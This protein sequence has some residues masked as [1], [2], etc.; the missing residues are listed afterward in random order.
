MHRFKNIL[1][2]D[3]G[4]PGFVR[5]LRRATDLARRNG[6]R[7]TLL[8]VSENVPGPT[9]KIFELVGLPAVQD[10]GVEDARRR[11]EEIVARH[12]END[13]R[14]EVVAVAGTPFLEVI[15]QVLRGENDLVIVNAEGGARS[16]FGSTVT[17]LLR[18]C[19]CPV[20]VLRPE[21]LDRY[22]R[23]LAAVE[24]NPEDEAREGLNR[25]ILEVATSLARLQDADL[26]IASAWSVVGEAAIRSRIGIPP[27]KLE[28]IMQQAEHESRSR[29][30]RLLDEV[31]TSDLELET[32]IAHGSP[33]VLIPE[34]G[35]EI[36]TEL[37]VIGTVGRTGIAGLLIGNT[38]E[39]ILSD[40][41]CPVLAIKPDGFRT[42][43]SLTAA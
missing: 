4:K 40:V 28:E 21:P 31:D 27:E 39:S 16:W 2:Y 30:D 43:V 24:A 26:H 17:H 33:G 22:R 14:V 9:R 36:Q 6:A 20:W 12:V 42:P 10:W 25:R 18:K 3:D 34:I 37:I 13:L 29:L 38:A 23:I 11:L 41:E 7:L 35:R 32:H 5:M 8:G 15:R 1:L 19:P